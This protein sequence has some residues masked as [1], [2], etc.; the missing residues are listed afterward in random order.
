LETRDQAREAGHATGVFLADL[1][2]HPRAPLGNILGSC[3]LLED[4]AYISPEQQKDLGVIRASGEYLSR[5]DA[6]LMDIATIETPNPAFEKVAFN[7]RELLRAVVESL[8]LRARKK[9]LQLRLEASSSW[10]R[11]AR[12]DARKLRQVL[13][14]LIGNAIEYT[15]QS[16]V[17]VRAYA[18]PTD[19]HNRVLSVEVED[20]GIRVAPYDQSR[21][22]E[23]F[24][25]AG[26]EAD[27]QG[28]GLTLSIS[29]RLIKLI[30][31]QLYLETATGEGRRFRI[32]L[33]VE[34]TEDSELSNG[35]STEPSL[36][37]MAPGQPEFRILIVDD[38]EESR[39]LLHRLLQGAGFRVMVARNSRETVETFRRWQPHLMCV[40][41]R[42]DLELV[43]TIRSL[44]GGREVRIAAMIPSALA[45]ERGSGA[46]ADADVDDFIPYPHPPDEIFQCL[47]RQLGVFYVHPEPAEGFTDDSAEAIRPEGIAALPV[48]LR[49]EL[50]EALVSLDA[51]RIAALIERVRERDAGLGAVLDHR[52]WKFSYTPILTALDAASSK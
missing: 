12:T 35:W 17:I 6:E 8:Q 29:R 39:V 16:G 25:Q 22:L 11:L 36:L 47:K 48:E 43:P 1:N 23:P 14:N 37:R 9:N 52:A 30:G 40:R 46:A 44:D 20:T 49:Q 33:P 10:P 7:P 13:V 19:D 28:A 27:Q 2:R 24:V 42:M 18:N 26:A 41:M 45:T 4:S 5:L 21:V 15:Q 31:G 34:L 51:R 3:S 38:D 32:E 50:S